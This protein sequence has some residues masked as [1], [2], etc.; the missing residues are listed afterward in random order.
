MSHPDPEAPTRSSSTTMVDGER[1]DRP[2][3]RSRNLL[4]D[5]VTR[6]LMDGL[7]AERAS[8]IVEDVRNGFEVGKARAGR[9]RP[10]RGSRR[11]SKKCLCKG[12]L[13]PLTLT[14]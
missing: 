2:A 7:F 5:V 13:L 3:R 12:R 8:T 6:R 1:S 11:L 10:G 9:P 14:I 4:L